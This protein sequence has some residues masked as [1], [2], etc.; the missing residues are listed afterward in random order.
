MGNRQNCAKFQKIYSEVMKLYQFFTLHLFANGLY[1]HILYIG[2][3][4]K[5]KF[6]IL[7]KWKINGF[8]CH[9]TWHL[10]V[11]NGLL[12]WFIHFQINIISSL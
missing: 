3:P 1:H 6:S 8:R 2:T 12:C 10:F 5:H 9:N 4:K 7:D 11:F